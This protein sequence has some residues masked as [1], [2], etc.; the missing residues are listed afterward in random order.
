[1]LSRGERAIAEER[2]GQNKEYSSR[3]R[4]KSNW[5]KGQLLGGLASGLAVQDAR[6]RETHLPRE[7]QIDSQ[8]L[9]E[10]NA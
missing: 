7:T 1:V 8:P 2:R 6:K 4:K 9:I 10:G 5:E 3:K